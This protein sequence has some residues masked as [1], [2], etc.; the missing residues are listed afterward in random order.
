MSVGAYMHCVAAGIS[1]PDQLAL[2]GFN[3][4]NLLRGLPIKLATT[5]AHRLVIGEAA[6]QIILDA[7][8]AAQLIQLE[9][10]AI[11]GQSL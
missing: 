3:N 2:A 10:Q 7:P 4:L 1:V 6:A 9:P 5:D 11:R 8:N